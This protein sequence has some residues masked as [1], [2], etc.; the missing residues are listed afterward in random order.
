[1]VRLSDID[2]FLVGGVLFKGDDFVKICNM[3]VVYYKVI[4]CKFRFG[5]VVMYLFDEDGEFFE[6]K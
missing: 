6:T 5:L 2:G 4:G 1:M 3:S